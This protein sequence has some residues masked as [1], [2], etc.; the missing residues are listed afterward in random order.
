MQVV[1]NENRDKASGIVN[2]QDATLVSSEGQTIV[3]HFPEG[4]QAFVY[5]ITHHIEG[6]GEVTRY[7]STPAYAR[8]TSKL[9][10]QNPKHPLVWLD[11]PV[12]PPWLAYITLSRV[13]RKADLS[14]MQPMLASQMAPVQA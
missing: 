7:P 9:Q 1:I 5:T 3:L 8:T 4:D 12:V 14:V 6:E 10:G 2:G 11:C 13:C